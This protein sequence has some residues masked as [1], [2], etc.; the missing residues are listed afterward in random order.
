[1]QVAERAEGG[2]ENALAGHA[3]ILRNRL[4]PAAGE[5]ED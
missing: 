1:V 3:A 2:E 4:Q 5:G